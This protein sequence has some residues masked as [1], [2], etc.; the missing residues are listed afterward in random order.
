MLIQKPPLII[1]SPDSNQRVETWMSYRWQ[2]RVFSCANVLLSGRWY[3]QLGSIWSG[4]KPSES[5]FAAASPYSRMLPCSPQDTLVDHA[6]TKSQSSPGYLCL[7]YA[8]HSTIMVCDKARQMCDMLNEPKTRLSTLSIWS[9]C[10]Q[11]LWYQGLPDDIG[12][13]T[14]ATGIGV[15]K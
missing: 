9:G 6:Y 8:I 12:C 11:I 2:S 1:S 4:Q 5:S 15:G 10:I 7:G 3:H 13:P 14:W